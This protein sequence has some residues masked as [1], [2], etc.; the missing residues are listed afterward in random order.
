MILK[1][2][3]LKNKLKRISKGLPEIED[4]L[5]FGSV[6]RGKSNPKDI[7]VLILFKKKVDKNVEYKIRKELE[8]HY[9]NI[10]II[11]KTKMNSLDPSFDARE[12]ILFEGTSLLSGKN[13]SERYGFS[14]VGMF[15]YNIKKWDNLKKTKFY[16]TLNGRSGKGGVLESFGG[17]K[18]SDNIILTPLDQIEQAKEFLDLWGLDYLYTPTL[19]PTRLNKKSILQQR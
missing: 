18:L 3:E 8:K 2:T 15:K 14:P 11:S 1:N 10:S 4:I 5:L 17:I 12:S 16:Y 13:L 6:V 19:I 9:K 7:D